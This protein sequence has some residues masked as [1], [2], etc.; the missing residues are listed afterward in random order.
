MLFRSN[1][2]DDLYRV[3]DD[4]NSTWWELLPG[5]N[6]IRIYADAYDATGGVTVSLAME[7]AWQMGGENL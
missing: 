2:T 1:G 5:D 4:A 7:T 3:F 6:D